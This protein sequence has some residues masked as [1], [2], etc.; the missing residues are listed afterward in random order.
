MILLGTRNRH[1]VREVREILEPLG[2]RCAVA[3]DLPAVEETGATFRQNAA[4]KALGAAAFCRGPVL[5]DDSGLVVPALGGE[6]GVRSS[7]YAGEEADDEA[8]LG[9][10][11]HRLKERGLGEPAGWFQCALALALPGE[12]LVE[13]EGR[14][15]GRILDAPRGRNGFGYDPVFFHPPS[16][17]TFAELPSDQKN[18]VSHRARALQALAERLPEFADRL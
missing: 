18:R 7:R 15:E 10:L 12:L 14:V 17:C 5:A 16:A 13:V 4:L 11:V 8:N 9:R 3:A 6:P 2:L 1:K